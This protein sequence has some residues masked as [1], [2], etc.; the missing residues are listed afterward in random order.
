MTRAQRTGLVALGLGGLLFAG[1]W[2]LLRAAS[3][4]EFVAG[5]LGA[6]LGRR[7]EVGDVQLH[8][9]GTLEVELW[10]LRIFE[11]RAPEPALGVERVVAQLRWPR[12][13]A[14]Q[15]LP[16]TWT[17]ERPVLRLPSSAGAPFRLEIPLR[18]LE[19]T[20]RDGTVVWGETD[21]G[22][23]KLT[24][25]QVSAR[26]RPLTRS[27][28]GTA[29]GQLE[30]SGQT[31]GSFSV[32]FDGRSD[33]V[34]AS[35]SV[36]GC[37]LARLPIP[38]LPPIRGT[39]AG[40]LTL[41]QDSAGRGASVN[42]AVTGLAINHPS[43]TAPIVPQDV[44]VVADVREDRR[45]L[46]IDFRPL[47]LDDLKL[48]GAIQVSRGEEPDARVVAQLS[49]DPFRLG[50]PGGRL[51]LLR[52]V[53]LRFAVWGRA[54]ERAEDGR[55]EDF[56]Y[57]LDVP[58]DL[59][60]ETLAFRRKAQLQELQIDARIEDGV[61]RTGPESPP[62]EAIH[63]LVSV[64]GNRLEVYDLRMTRE[65]R[66]FPEVDITV[67]GL[68]R[69]AR[70]PREERRTPKGPGVAIPGL[71]PTFAALTSMA[72]KSDEERRAVL[73]DLRL[74]YPAFVLPIRDATATVSFPDG[75]V[76]IEK[77]EGVVGGALAEAE[78]LWDRPRNQVLVHL[79][80]LDGE[81]PPGVVRETPWIEGSLEV[82]TAY[83]GP[84]PLEEIEGPIQGTGARIHL[85][86]IEARL[87]DGRLEASGDLD[88][89]KPEEG[90]VRLRFRH[91]EGDA[92]A[93]ARILGMGDDRLTGK[94]DAVGT[95]EG[96]LRPG[97]RFTD[98]GRIETKVEVRDGTLGK[99]P[100]TLTLARLASVQGWTG[101]F[102]R[103]LPFKTLKT[104]LRVEKGTLHVEEFNL[105]GPEL[106]ILSAGRME[107]HEE[108]RPVDLLV[109][110]LLFNPV[111]WV[112]GTVPV[113]GDWI[114]G[115]DRSLV[116]LYFRLEGPWESPDGSYVPPQT[117]RTASGWA[118]RIVVGGVRGLRNLLLPGR[119]GAEPESRAE[120]EAGA[121]SDPS[122]DPE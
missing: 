90:K 45:T 30:H 14:G 111:N 29:M 27:V 87:A 67:D 18:P 20:I 80:Y 114:L 50:R 86:A 34:E 3:G 102:G 25:L 88:L 93:V 106:R 53:G 103:P 40:T 69:L 48:R 120:P 5:A 46:R 97:D 82:E 10:D 21:G 60:S 113:I 2:L 15:L 36:S 94:L 37:D 107:L 71:G 105:V 56:K 41:H 17:L 61:Y 38:G 104:S 68:D 57:R 84:W 43:L 65:G 112:I 118:E 44:R 83:V 116:A 31:L 62:L 79:A 1:G 54:D 117:L 22:A 52:L 63:G 19:L 33:A 115:E 4:T 101:L 24:Q 6:L 51:Q 76:L 8:A 58:R 92:S 89:G 39:A 59:L 81:A 28:R 96:P 99:G 16:A 47:V 66:A 35:G 91:R 72:P 70:L 74:G 109:A 121:K 85:P 108:N 100:L 49:L 7:V 75:N 119:S 9:G 98:V 12:L 122:G 64:R 110:L 42:L 73:R 13:L 55:I 11:D 77:L 95:L 32:E 23:A 26:S 78:A